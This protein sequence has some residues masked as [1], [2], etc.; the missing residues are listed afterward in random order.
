MP[1]EGFWYG[2]L[3]MD[4]NDEW[5]EIGRGSGVRSP[6]E[7]ELG[8]I[9]GTKQIRIMFKP[10]HNPGIAAKLNRMTVSENTLGIDAVEALH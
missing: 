8:E 3:V 10:H 4:R 9:S 1:Q 7:F 5:R 2:V 6:D